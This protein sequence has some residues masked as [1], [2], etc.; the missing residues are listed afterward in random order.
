MW[1]VASGCARASS[2]KRRQGLSI[3]FSGSVSRHS[4]GMQNGC[5]A[6]SR[7]RTGGSLLAARQITCVLSRHWDP[8]ASDDLARIDISGVGHSNRGDKSGAARA[9]PRRRG[10]RLCARRGVRVHTGTRGDLGA[11]PPAATHFEDLL[12]AWNSHPLPKTTRPRPRACSS[13][14]GRGTRLSSSG[15]LRAANA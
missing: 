9:R 14:P 4:R 7:A 8:P 11:A 15:T 13:R 6:S 5:E 2:L 10:R 3:N 12:N 1:E